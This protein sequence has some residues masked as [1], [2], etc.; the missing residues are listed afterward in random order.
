MATR[1]I[2]FVSVLLAAVLMA[3]APA[4]PVRAAGVV[5]DGTAGSCTEAAFTAAL[6][7][8]GTVSFNCGGPATIPIISVK[9]IAQ[10]TIIDG[11]GEITLD[12]GLTTRLFVV[13][14]GATLRLHN[15]IL[16]SA[17]AIG[18]D[19]GAISNQ[20]TL[21][22]D[23]ST[24]RNSQTD[25]DHSGGAIFS[26]GP[27]FITDSTISDNT[28]G[29]AG[30]IF[31]N[32]GNAAVT[33]SNSVFSGNRAINTT[34]GYGG[35]VWVGSLATLDVTGGQM[36]NNSARRGGALYLSP[37]ATATL[38]GERTFMRIQD[39]TV[40][41]DGGAIA[42]EG[43]TL[44]VSLVDFA[45]NRAP[46][47]T[48][49]I[50]YGGAIANMGT[51]AVS[52]SFFRMNEGR[53]GA[54]VL[55]GS[56][57]AGTG[58]A[59]A[60]IAGSSFSQN[61]AGLLGGGLYANHENSVVTIADSAFDGNTAD[62]GGGMARF[63][64]QVRIDR[65]SFTNNVAT[66]GGG[67]SVGSGPT[68]GVG[69]Y[70]EVH[71]TTFSTNTAGSGQGGGVFNSFGLINLGHVTIK[72][73]SNGMFNT[74]AGAGTRMFNTVLD[75]PGSLNCDG[76]GTLPSSAGGNY[77]NDNSCGLTGPNDTQGAG[78]DPKLGPLTRDPAGLT[79]YH[80]PAA[81]SPLVDAAVP[82][83]S[84]MDQRRALRGSACDIGAVEYG[85]LLPLAYLPLVNR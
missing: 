1:S 29:S 12:G 8:G 5:G 82:P 31:A 15:I 42:N 41:E 58:A 70:V 13:N 53:F 78:L 66:R 47:N 2:R 14:S 59:T 25:I 63:N 37:N 28:G 6:T 22:L 32:F 7:G 50:G 36:L 9:T 27:V 30:A 34:F 62:S 3:A 75:N 74:G 64:A 81:D 18:S 85:G 43:G 76:D 77:S 79:S 73:N 52:D 57:F 48:I 39:N 46:M 26:L 16:A 51:L 49:G 65:S 61:T 19:G 72:D 69:G 67:L 24:I 20:G 54:A 23:N 84:T 56:A 80:V 68:A 38:R 35:A 83:C 33:I 55:T 45:R 11:S 40:T 44:T 21:Y 4:A 17:Y 71:D 60:T 10:D